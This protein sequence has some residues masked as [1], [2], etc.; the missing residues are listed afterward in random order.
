VW[1]WAL[2]LAAVFAGWAIVTRLR[3][4][5][6]PFLGAMLGSI[7]VHATGVIN[8]APSHEIVVVAGA[9]LGSH[10][11]SRFG[12]LRFGD[13]A[14]GAP[15]VLALA[16]IMVLIGAPVGLLVG[17]AVGVGPMAGMM[18]FAPGSMEVMV[19]VALALNAH[20]T[21]VAAHHPARTSLLIATMPALA[22]LARRRTPKDP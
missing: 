15:A 4:P 7:A 3:W 8:A 11:G 16:G 9:L 6:A 22:V 10:I 19:A 1:G 5:S 17:S 18:A 21:Y 13:I 14:R 12:G 2:A 20:P